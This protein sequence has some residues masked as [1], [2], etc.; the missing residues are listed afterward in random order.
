MFTNTLFVLNYCSIISPQAIF[1]P[2]FPL[3]CVVK[4]SGCECIITVLPIISFTVNLFIKTDIK[5]YPLFEKSGGKSP[6]WYG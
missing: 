1:F 2:E 3:G 5:A 6:A 4:A